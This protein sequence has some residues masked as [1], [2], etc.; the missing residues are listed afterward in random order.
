[1]TELGRV[2]DSKHVRIRIKKKLIP[3][4]LSRLPK[5]VDLTIYPVNKEDEDLRNM[6]FNVTRRFP[7]P[8]ERK[9]KNDIDNFLSI[10]SKIDPRIK[11]VSDKVTQRDEP[12]LMVNPWIK[13]ETLLDAPGVKNDPELDKQISKAENVHDV[14]IR[15]SHIAELHKEYDRMKSEYIRTKFSK[16]DVIDTGKRDLETN[17]KIYTV[18]QGEI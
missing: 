13:I 3:K 5:G 17:E 10:L 7:N 6:T 1:M 11:L 15:E 8:L 2:V 12:N 18:R 4:L 9:D 16:E 14:E